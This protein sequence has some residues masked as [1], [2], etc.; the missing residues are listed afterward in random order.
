MK[1]FYKTELGKQIEYHFNK[2]EFAVYEE[3][4]SSIWGNMPL[5]LTWSM[6]TEIYKEALKKYNEKNKPP[7]IKVSP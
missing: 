7:H 4:C 2:E 5:D 3:V 1:P 6:N